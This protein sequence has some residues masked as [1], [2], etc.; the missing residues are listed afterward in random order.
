MASEGTGSVISLN[1][2]PPILELLEVAQA[3]GGLGLGLGAGQRRQQH[4]GQD[5]N[6]G[7]DPTFQRWV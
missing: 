2:V 6:D 3:L 4:R 1:Y 5:G 7:D